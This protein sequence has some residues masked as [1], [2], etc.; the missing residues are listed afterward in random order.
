V[1]TLPASRSSPLV[2]VVIP[3]YNYGAF[4]TDAVDSALGQTYPSVEIIVVDDGSE[5]D[6]AA[7]IARYGDR[8]RY[9]HQQNQGLSAAR[10]LGI[11]LANG[12]WVAFLD[13]DDIWHPQK[14]QLQ[15]AALCA[16]PDIVLLGA[17]GQAIVG[18]APRVLPSLT[19]T[20]ALRRLGL[21]DF[22]V[23]TPF[24][25]SSMLVRRDLFEE[26]G[27]FDV[28]LRSVE[29]R[30]M[31]LRLAAG[32]ASGRVEAV[33]W[34]YREHAGQMS[35]NAHRMYESYARVL[36]NFFATHPEREGLRRAA[37]AFMYRDASIA[38]SEQNERGAAIR[39]ML[40]SLAAW[41]LPL[42]TGSRGERVRILTRLLMGA[43]LYRRLR[44]LIAGPRRAT[45]ALR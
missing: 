3:S 37:T 14:L 40:K 22:L 6:T 5:D 8:V 32:H 26:V 30:D 12:E 45:S 11:R 19:D 21:R 44:G 36:D 31:Y 9:H 39:L 29:D 4:V 2:S 41:P 33:S 43:A 10:N 28:R 20:P 38:L 42:T 1:V 16:N 24:A 34:Y 23:G 27:L 15:V 18:E 35:R 17:Q 7:R 25:P 13:A